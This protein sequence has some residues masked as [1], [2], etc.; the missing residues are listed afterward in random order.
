M[1]NELYNFEPTKDF[2]LAAKHNGFI[3][4]NGN[5]YLVSEKSKHIPTH[6][7]WANSYIVGKLDF[8]KLL[9]NPNKSLIYTLNRLKEKQDMLIHF[10]GYV[11]YSHDSY[12]NKP[13]II[14]PDEKVNDKKVS[15]EQLK[16]LFEVMKINGEE[17]YFPSDIDNEIK[18]KNHNEY[19]D[20]FIIKRLK[21]EIKK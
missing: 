8:V 13:I 1:S 7:Q 3:D 21:E 20:D 15:N 19:V 12:T 5:Y 10:Y 16:T 18:N 14:L 2:E 11:Y 17:S 6:E 4:P 9:A